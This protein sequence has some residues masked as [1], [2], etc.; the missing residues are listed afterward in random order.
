MIYSMTGY[1]SATRELAATSGNGGVSVSVE[2]RTVNSRFLDL[3]FR[4]P[5]DVRV[6]EPTLRE[7][8]MNKLSRGKVDIRINLQRSEQSAIS[9]ALNRDALDHLA[10]LERAVVSAFPEAGAVAY[11]GK[12][13]AGR[14]CSRKER[15][16]AGCIA[17]GSARVRQAGDCRSD[18]CARARRRAARDDADR[19][20]HRNGSDRHEDH[21]ARAGADCEASA[22]DRRTAAG[23]ARHRRTG[24]G[25]NDR[26]A[27]R[28][29]RAHSP[30]SHDVRHSH[31][32][33]RRTV[34]AHRASE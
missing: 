2:L 28:D 13:C 7:M 4:M 33:R 16:V 27:R 6:C 15:R 34:A 20:R 21:A 32:H 18:R 25:C 26:I 23:S 19:E 8:L 17:R 11:R 24:C 1:A 9:G 10:V 31:R 29:R 22:E 3:N 30:G 5:E 12:F 14:A